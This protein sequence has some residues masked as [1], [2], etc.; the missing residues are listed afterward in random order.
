MRL[1][2]AR[3]AGRVGLRASVGELW[4]LMSSVLR[5]ETLTGWSS[6]TSRTVAALSK[7]VDSSTAP[8]PTNSSDAPSRPEND[9][10]R[11]RWRPGFVFS[12]RGG[13]AGCAP[14][15]FVLSP[16]YLLVDSEARRRPTVT[17]KPPVRP[18]RPRPRIARPATI[19]ELV[20]PPDVP[21]VASAAAIGDLAAD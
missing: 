18:T 5:A 14:E 16:I 4:A 10:P 11:P 13:E 17:R 2:T 8:M 19:T 21:A 1:V 12:V 6:P 15:S 3:F 9:E 20:P 7:A